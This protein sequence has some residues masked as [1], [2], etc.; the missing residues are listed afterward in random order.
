MRAAFVAETVLP[1]V[2][3]ARSGGP[4]SDPEIGTQIQTSPYPVTW[5]R[6]TGDM[7]VAHL[8]SSDQRVP[9]TSA[10]NPAP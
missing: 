4:P 10:P 5:M 9:E 7:R 6:T 8:W 3:L 2:S 1:R